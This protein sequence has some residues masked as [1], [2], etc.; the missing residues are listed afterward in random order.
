[1]KEIE[2]RDIFSDVGPAGGGVIFQH[3]NEK[4]T[5]IMVCTAGNY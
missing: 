2:S 3:L 4:K 5:E 1:M